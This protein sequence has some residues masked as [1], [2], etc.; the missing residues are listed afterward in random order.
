M[1]NQVSRAPADCKSLG[2]GMTSFRLA[3]DF[4]FCRLS[5]ISNREPDCY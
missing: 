1:H 2:V 5:Y 3:V 4:D